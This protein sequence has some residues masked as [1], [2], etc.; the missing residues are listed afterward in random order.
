[1]GMRYLSARGNGPATATHVCGSRLSYSDQNQLWVVEPASNGA[2]RIRHHASGKYME[3]ED[4]SGLEGAKIVLSEKTD[5]P[6]QEWQVSAA[7]AGHVK[8][9]NRH[10]GLALRLQRD[11]E[12]GR[13]SS[14]IQARMD[15]SPGG[16]WDAGS[17]L[18]AEVYE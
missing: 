15:S 2:I 6:R 7:A 8:L 14:L 5:H 9:Q 17:V 16:P 12:H 13:G 10:S 18:L 3:P 11:E 4:G 1:M